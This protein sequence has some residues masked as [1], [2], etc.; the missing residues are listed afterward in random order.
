MYAQHLIFCCSVNAQY[1]L[2]MHISAAA[3]FF[4]FGKKKM[5]RLK[6]EYMIRDDC[7]VTMCDPS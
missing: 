5:Q 4:H 3:D 7:N 1:K 2:C 6:K